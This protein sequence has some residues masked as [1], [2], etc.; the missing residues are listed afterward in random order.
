MSQWAREHPEEMERIS[1]LPMNEQNAAMRAAIGSDLPTV[2]PHGDLP[3]R[4]VV[5]DF[6]RIVSN[7]QS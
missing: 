4:S 3:K 2:Y 5:D 7:E 1:R 6:K